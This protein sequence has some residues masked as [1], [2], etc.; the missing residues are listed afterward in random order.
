MT[1]ARSDRQTR[2]TKIRFVKFM[3]FSLMVIEIVHSGWPKLEFGTGD[4]CG[5]FRTVAIPP[6]IAD[7][8]IVASFRNT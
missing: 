6:K 2:I 3:T 5:S 8:V 7:Q 1:A 4:W